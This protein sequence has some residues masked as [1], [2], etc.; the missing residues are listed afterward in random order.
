MEHVDVGGNAILLDQ[1]TVDAEY[2]DM[3]EQTISR[4]M[5]RDSEYEK[6]CQ[7]AEQKGIKEFSYKEIARR[8]IGIK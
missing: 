4:L 1:P 3:L 8:A 7:V 6:M 2:I 5:G